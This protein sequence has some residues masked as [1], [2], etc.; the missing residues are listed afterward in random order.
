M[1]IPSQFRLS[2]GPVHDL[3]LHD[4][5]CACCLQE[6]Q[7]RGLGLEQ[8]RSWIYETYSLT[9]YRVKLH[10]TQQVVHLK[11]IRRVSRSQMPDALCNIQMQGRRQ[12]CHGSMSVWGVTEGQFGAVSGVSQ[13]EPSGWRWGDTHLLDHATWLIGSHYP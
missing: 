6:G 13:A 3:G 12:G 9:S 7:R 4:V 8:L 5:Y 1:P 11:V 2:T 10:L